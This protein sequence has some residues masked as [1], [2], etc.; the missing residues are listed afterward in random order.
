MKLLSMKYEKIMFKGKKE[1]EVFFLFLK[2]CRSSVCVHLSVA[3]S[4]YRSLWLQAV[5]LMM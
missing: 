2:I 5:L 1:N 4:V 3:R